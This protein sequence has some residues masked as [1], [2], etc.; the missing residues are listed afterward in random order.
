MSLVMHNIS[1]TNWWWQCCRQRSNCCISGCTRGSFT[2]TP[3]QASFLVWKSWIPFQILRSF[4][5]FRGF[6]NPRDCLNPRDFGNPRFFFPHNLCCVRFFSPE[7]PV[8]F[9]I[10]W[11]FFREFFSRVFQNPRDFC[12]PFVF[13]CGNRGFHKSTGFFIQVFSEYLAKIP[14]IWHKSP[15]FEVTL[16]IISDYSI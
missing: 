6:Q 14:C 7:N 12:E 3:S 13:S 15:T 1:A 4:F 8:H 2:G 5:K 9:K 10:P 11:I 16:A